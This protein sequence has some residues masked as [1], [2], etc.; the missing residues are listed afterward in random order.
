MVGVLR[1]SHDERVA[2]WWMLGIMLLLGLPGGQVRGAE[3]AGVLGLTAHE[4]PLLPVN[5]EGD[6]Y[7][8]NLIYRELV[9]QGVLMIARDQFG[10]S[11]RDQ[12]L[13]EPLPGDGVS[14]GLFDIEVAHVQGKRV[15]YTLS[16]GDEL[17]YEDTARFFFGQRQ[18]TWVVLEP[19]Y[20][21]MFGP[22]VESL[23]AHGL[24]HQ[25]LPIH[26]DGGGVTPEMEAALLRMDVASQYVALRL[27]HEA[28]QTHGE[29]RDLL[30]VLSRGYGNLGQFAMFHNSAMRYVFAARGLWYATRLIR[31]EPDVPIGYWCRSY[32]GGM[33][34]FQKQSIWDLSYARDRVDAMDHPPSVPRWVE[35]VDLSNRYR[36]DDLEAATL[37]D[38]GYRELAAFLWYRSNEFTG[39]PLLNI[40]AGQKTLRVIPHCMRVHEGISRNAG[41]RRG[42]QITTRSIETISETLPASLERACEDMPELFGWFGDAVW[43]CDT[44]QGRYDFSRAMVEA[45]GVDEDLAEPSVAVLGMLVDEQNVMQIAF[46]AAYL[47]DARGQDTW[48]YLNEMQPALAGHPHEPLVMTLGLPRN[49][50]LIHFQEM[51][52]DYRTAEGSFMM[53]YQLLLGRMSED[54]RIG[55][56]RWV[57]DLRVLIYHNTDGAEPEYIYKLLMGE[58]AERVQYA[59][60]AADVIPDSPLRYA[61]LIQCDW[62]NNRQHADDWERDYGHHPVVAFTLAQGFSQEGDPERALELFEVYRRV[63]PDYKVHYSICAEYWRSLGNPAAA[64]RV[65]EAFFEEED[66]R[67][68]HANLARYI[69]YAWMEEGDYEAALP[70]ADRAGRSAYWENLQAQ[71]YCYEHLGLHDEALRL[72]Q[73]FDRQLGQ[74]REIGAAFRLGADADEAWRI[75]QASVERVWDDPESV[76]PRFRAEHDLLFHGTQTAYASW[77]GLLEID[78]RPL[79]LVFA[80]MLAAESG[81]MDEARRLWRMVAHTPVERVHPTMQDTAPVFIQIAAAFLQA[82]DGEPLDVDAMVELAGFPN[83]ALYSPVLCMVAMALDVLA[84]NSQE[85]AGLWWDAA[86]CPTREFF[87]TLYAMRKVRELG[88]DPMIGMISWPG[89]RVDTDLEFIDE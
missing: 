38:D 61:T 41:W 54:V 37:L 17:V 64:E 76:M 19:L 70:W 50:E 35:L 87:T 67:W 20:E 73:R 66:Y 25:P 80:G 52:E 28:M 34:G 8:P 89:L 59:K 86:T 42:N 30:M 49:A 72:W 82:F 6:F 55:D 75:T 44:V 63:I 18:S 77:Q 43:D 68:E 7:N 2:A 83:D 14:P 62:E 57:Q 60:W 5:D 22:V 32:A 46:R 53:T 58:N 26:L 27:A 69:A 21:Q 33:F 10:L 71:A 78:N 29:T 74:H 56:G 4:P 65:A 1:V 3:S 13:R 31:L 81:D 15:E 48:P 85:A 40:E 23:K 84:P 88:E 39:I 9:R 11:T 16:H 24:E 51:L 36:S 47:R 45:A 12:V 79:F